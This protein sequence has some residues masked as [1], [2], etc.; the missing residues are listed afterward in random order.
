M[1]S[2]ILYELAFKYKKT[3]LWE[4]LNEAEVFA[5]E[6]SNGKTGY[7][8]IT[9]ASGKHISLSVFTRG[10]AYNSYIDIITADEASAGS[11]LLYQEKILQ[12][13]CLQCLFCDKDSLSKNEQ[14]RTRNYARKHGISLKGSNAWPRFINYQ[15]G[16][17]P[18]QLKKEEDVKYL[19]EAF[20]AAIEIAEI[21]KSRPIEEI[22]VK[23]AGGGTEKIP[24]L[25]SD[26]SRYQTR[27]TDLPER[28]PVQYIVPDMFNEINV[29]KLRNMQKNGI[30]ECELVQYPVP[31]QN[32]PGEI[33]HF[34]MIFLAAEANTGF[35]LP[36]TPVE[37]YKEKPGDLIDIIVDAFLGQ[38][39]CP[40]TMEVRDKRTYYFVQMLCKKLKTGLKIE[41]FLKVLDDAEEALA[42]Q[43]EKKDNSG[44]GELIDTLNKILELPPDELINLPD[45]AIGQLETAIKNNMLP[46]DISEELNEVLRLI[47]KIDNIKKDTSTNMPAEARTMEDGTNPDKTKADTARINK[48]RA[49]KADKNKTQNITRQ[50][51]VVINPAAKSYIISVSCGTGCYRH[52]QISGD[53]T[54][55]DLHSAILAAF[56]FDDDHAHAFFMDNVIWSKTDA[57]YVKGLEESGRY[58]CDY[59]LCEAGLVPGKQFKYVFDFGDE[60][61]FQC[62]VLRAVA[63]DTKSPFVTRTKGKA[64]EQYRDWD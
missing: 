34:P 59:K 17:V 43:W 23:N 18:W 28:Q 7:I 14:D 49:D 15:P 11:R 13:D 24:L 57:Y 2:D 36:V 26:G 53:N 64:P 39:V 30:W 52:I 50:K 35:I 62:K 33:P 21:L 19:M 51:V 41:P 27:L 3:G 46:E 40:G 54:L 44:A 12:Q 16:Y 38:N 32:T 22:W 47:K 61:L 63:V 9:G 48:A 56:G 10:E 37:Y 42:E 25:G 45:I 8:T 29:A 58:T 60:W 55:F 5:L 6:F 31:V 1:V 20:G 4:M